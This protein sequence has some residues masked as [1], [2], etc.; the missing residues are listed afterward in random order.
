MNTEALELAQKIITTAT[1]QN[2]RIGTC[3]SCTGGLAC[4]TL[5]AIPGSSRCIMG[6]VVSYAIE[7]K[8]KLLGVNPQTL[9]NFGAVSEQCA[10][11]MAHGGLNALDCTLCVSITGIAGP[12]GATRTKPVGMVCFA[13]ADY[14]TTHT[15]TRVFKGSR[16]EVREQSVVF[17]LNLIADYLQTGF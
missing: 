2:I 3:E 10:L 1:K 6:C 11:E 5:T 17:A 7:I 13:L 12:D 8:E 14:T 16:N 4:T 9:E 15:F